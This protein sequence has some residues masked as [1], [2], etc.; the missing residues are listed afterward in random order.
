MNNSIYLA[1]S[2]QTA[3][4]RQMSVV[5]NNVANANT[6]GFR[7]ES[8]MFNEYMVNAGN[9]GKISFVNDAATI[10]STAPGTFIDTG[11][12]LDAAIKGKGFFQ[13]ETPLGTRYTRQ[14]NFL[15]DATG[16]L[17]T[18]DGYPVQG[19]GG[20]ITLVE[21]DSQIVIREDGMITAKSATGQ[22]EERGRLAV[23]KFENETAMKQAGQSFYISDEAPVAAELN[24]D[25]TIA[26]GMLEQSN[27]NSV[28]EITSMIKINRSVGTTSKIMSDLHELE[29]RAVSVISKQA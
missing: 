21:G 6:D 10:T 13:V 24:E 22:V 3:L 2:K 11:R 19:E 5:A 20:P 18:P 17:V 29:R 8:V 28:S 23:M 25:F 27:V 7:S 4:F 16:N 12:S 1:L 9:S 26:G 15:T 14:G